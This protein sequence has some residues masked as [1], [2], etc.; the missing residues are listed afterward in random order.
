MQSRAGEIEA[1][2]EAVRARI[3]RACE[4]VRRDPSEVTLIAV[5]KTVGVEDV[6]AAYDLGLRDFGESRLQES[7]PKLDALP[8]DVTWHFI[9]RLQSNKARKAAARFSCVH[10]L[11]SEGQLAEIERGEHPVGGLV[12]VNIAD[13]PQKS[14]IPAEMLDEFV[15]TVAKYKTVRFRGLMTVGPAMRN[16]ELMRPYFQRMREL[17][18]RV[19]GEWLS[20]GMSSDLEVAIQEGSTHVR[21]GTA[22]F[23]ERIYN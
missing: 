5:T 4:A 8:P 12:E 9:G 3:A 14:G 20:M 21:I 13:E 2:L 17:R 7:L 15:E 18:Q 16:A 22:L 19:G 10:T 1:N 6:R 23:G 11:E